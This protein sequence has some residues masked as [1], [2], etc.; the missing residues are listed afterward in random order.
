MKSYCIRSAFFLVAVTFAAI[1]AQEDTAT[2]VAPV[3]C[4]I[5]C[6]EL[7]DA[8]QSEKNTLVQEKD[9]LVKQL[10]ETTG[11]KDTLYSQVQHV[12]EELATSISSANEVRAQ[13]VA[14]E[15]E[16]NKH[17]NE[18]E[19]LRNSLDQTREEMTHYQK[20]AQDNQ[21]YMQDYKNELHTQRDKANKLSEAL[22]EAN[23]KIVDLESTTFIKQLQ[24]EITMAWSAIVEYWV[25][26]KKKGK[27]D[28]DA[29]F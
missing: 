24:K 5:V 27:S 15:E 23:L 18:Y 17:F 19:S 7:V 9:A 26:L 16:K 21:K 22:N 14:V 11:H 29:E 10:E 6:K 2:T 8:V 28:V 13:L 20:V 25:N 4:D 1:S 12:R 3:D